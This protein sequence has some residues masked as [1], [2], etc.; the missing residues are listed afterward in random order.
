MVCGFQ[1]DV[2]GL[3]PDTWYIYYD[4]AK[5]K[6]YRLFQITNLRHN[7]FI[8]QQ[9]VRYTTILNIFRAARC[10]SSGGQIVYHHSPKHV[11]EQLITNKSIF[12]ASSWFS[13]LFSVIFDGIFG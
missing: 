12:V 10:S 11:E 13:P 5:H 1:S 8:L 2:R 7:S 6:R 9:Y 4:C 3:V